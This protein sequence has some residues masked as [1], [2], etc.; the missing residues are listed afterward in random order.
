MHIYIE[1]CK[2]RTVSWEHLFFRNF[3][4]HFC[5]SLVLKMQRRGDELK[6]EEYHLPNFKEFVSKFFICEQLL[7]RFVQLK[8][9][10]FLA[11]GKLQINH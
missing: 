2:D 4:R 3:R 9:N 11:C 6:K 1:R 8:L 5:T 7:P 10:I